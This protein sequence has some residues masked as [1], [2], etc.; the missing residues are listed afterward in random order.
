MI[1]AKVG[2]TVTRMLAGV[3]EMKLL[4]TDVTDTIII[5]GAWTFDRETGAEI[6]HDLGWGA[7]PMMTG[8]FLVQ[9]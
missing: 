2:D 1:D 8:S 4:V 3:V 7:P 6:D 5:C 9:A